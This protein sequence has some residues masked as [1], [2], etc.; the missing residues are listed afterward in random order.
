MLLLV[1]VYNNDLGKAKQEKP[2]T[3]VELLGICLFLWSDYGK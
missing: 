2:Q 1:L 3:A